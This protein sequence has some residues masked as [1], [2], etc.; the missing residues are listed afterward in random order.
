LQGRFEEG[1][2]EATEALSR[3]PMSGMLNSGLAFVLMLARRYDECVK[4]ALT[5]TEVDPPMALCYWTLGAAYEA[6][7]MYREAC[8]AYEKCF[9]IGGAHGYLDSFAAHNHVRNGD[10]AK[11]WEVVRRMKEISKSSYVPEMVFVVAYEGL[12]ENELAIDALQKAFARR[13]TN[14]VMIKTWPHF[15][16][17]R[18][19]PRFQ[20]V[21]RRVG[22]RR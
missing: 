14:L 2:R 9:E 17:L 3:D 21:E 16:N 6:K 13:E 18:D 4:Q 7:G 12:G 8:D 15:D 11:A 19:D 10:T 5:A 22:L 1:I 20:E